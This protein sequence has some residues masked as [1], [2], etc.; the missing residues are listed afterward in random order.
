MELD[1][2]GLQSFA[3]SFAQ[4][5][6][7]LLN[8]TVCNGI[9]LNVVFI[10]NIPRAY[11]GFGITK[12]APVNRTAVPLSIDAKAPD[13]YLGFSMQLG[14]DSHGQFPMVFQSVMTLATSPDSEPIVHFDYERGKKD[15]YHE[16]HMQIDAECERWEDVRRRRG[17][18]RPLAKLHFPA[19]GRRYRPTLE[20]FVRFLICEGMATPRPGWEALVES[21]QTEFDRKQLKAAVRNDPDA[22]IEALKKMK[23]WPGPDGQ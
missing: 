2:K 7:H 12:T 14:V 18:T 4:D 9:R 17:V 1:S 22:A 19:G 5:C 20:D 10:P 15:G 23:L 21:G 16:A 6:T 11:I 13:F 8:G 3:L